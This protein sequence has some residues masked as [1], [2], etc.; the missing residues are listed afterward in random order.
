MYHQTMSNLLR[1]LQD[2]KKNAFFLPISLLF[3]GL[4]L[5]FFGLASI[6][7]SYYHD[8]LDYVVT[9]LAFAESG[10]DLGGDWQPWHLRPVQTLNRTAELTPL[11]HGLVYQLLKWV[12]FT[13]S[14]DAGR[15]P[16]ALFGMATVGLGGVA[17]AR[18]TKSWQIGWWVAAA[19]AVSPWH[20]FISRTGFEGSISLFFQV[21][22]VWA[23]YEWLFFRPKVQMIQQSFALPSRFTKLGWLLLVIVGFL[24]GFY[25]YHAAK[26]TLLTLSLVGIIAVW[27]V[28]KENSV[29]LSKSISAHFWSKLSLTLV[30]VGLIAVS[31]MHVLSLQRQ[32]YLG[33]RA[34]ELI[35][36]SEYLSKAVNDQ[37]RMS[38]QLGA[39]PLGRWIE[40]ISNNK[41]TVLGTA[42]IHQ[43]FSAFDLYRLF[44]TGYEGG[45]QF[46]LIVHGYFYLS[47]LFFIPL[48]AWWLA[49]ERPQASFYL[50]ILLLIS[51]VASAIT[52]STQSLFRS[53]LTYFLLISLSGIGSWYFFV[54]LWQ[55]RLIGA[56]E[57]VF[58]FGCILISSLFLISQSLWFGYLYFSQ[59]PVR[60]IDNHDFE[61]R[62]L[63]EYIDRIQSSQVAQTQ[64]D[65]IV[66]KVAKTPWS[67][68]RAY[69]G[70]SNQVSSLTIQE[71]AAFKDPL[72]TKLVLS[73]P[74]IPVTF[75][76]DCPD[77]SDVSRS[78]SDLET[79]QIAQ[80]VIVDAA[81]FQECEISLSD[82]TSTREQ[83]KDWDEVVQVTGGSTLVHGLGSPL[84]SRAYFWVLDDRYCQD[85]ELE[86]FI[87]LDS[88]KQFQFESLSDQAFCQQWMKTERKSF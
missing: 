27:I 31:T 42:L 45:F 74:K 7:F 5:R 64:F 63:S 52:I 46:S 12:S 60:A 75:Q 59:Y 37:R 61:Y 26:F 86:S 9:G 65:E 20:V 30:F 87:R 29:T 34:T 10:S 70:Y 35:F 25:T 38:I 49:K 32:G 50:G 72:T 84:D 43:Y 11:V 51:P 53:A 48:G 40:T 17:L 56:R 39:L 18:M 78:K 67:V 81:A 16:A 15:W 79:P 55:M 3:L 33:D 68:A 80:L 77:F 28:P 36:S 41:L 85:F 54:W 47:A 1:F 71:R 69:V 22:A 13:P 66:V 58:K 76:T 21:L 24:G 73:F 19:L 23:F 44:V 82:L 88:L 62:L 57:R 2:I 8:E 6:P 4:A 14:V 83:V